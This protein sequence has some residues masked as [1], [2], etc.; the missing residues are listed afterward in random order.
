MAET[1]AAPKPDDWRKAFTRIS[2]VCYVTRK[3]RELHEDDIYDCACRQRVHDDGSVYACEDT[4]LNRIS[5]VECDPDTCNHG[6]FCRNQRFQ[7][8]Q[9]APLEVF[10]AD[11]K[12]WGIRAIQDVSAGQFVAEYLGELVDSKEFVRR[13]AQYT[14]EGR[15]HLFSMHISRDEIIDS[16]MKGS[17]SR[18]INHSC[19]PNCEAQKWTVQGETRIGFFTIKD[20]PKGTEFTFDYQFQTFGDTQQTCYCGSDNCRGTIGIPSRL[21]QVEVTSSDNSD[22]EVDF[23]E[24]KTKRLK[25]HRSRAGEDSMEEED[26]EMLV[27]RKVYLVDPSLCKLDSVVSRGQLETRI[28]RKQVFETSS[29]QSLVIVTAAGTQPLS[30]S[31]TTVSTVSSRTTIVGQ[32]ARTSSREDWRDVRRYEGQELIGT[33]VLE[34]VLAWDR[35]KPQIDLHA[36]NKGMG[37]EK[38][39]CGVIRI[40][41]EMDIAQLIGCTL[42]EFR[43]K[44]FKVL[45]NLDTKVWSLVEP[46]DPDVY[47]INTIQEVQD[48][49]QGRKLN[50]IKFDAQASVRP[51][52]LVP[53]PTPPVVS[54][55]ASS[56]ST[57]VERS[58]SDMEIDDAAEGN[59]SSAQRSKG[60]SVS[61]EKTTTAVSGEP[62]THNT[63]HPAAHA[64]GDAVGHA[65]AKILAEYY[66]KNKIQTKEDFK[67]LVVS[68]QKRIRQ[69]EAKRK[70]GD[71]ALRYQFT[72]GTRAGINHFVKEFFAKLS[73]GQLPVGYRHHS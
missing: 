62:D 51:P 48:M 60:E 1:S 29:L 49:L 9:N 55:P 6:D 58:L 42:R 72:D 14:K 5:F 67:A 45:C 17:E 27:R 3:K 59:P 23:A 20:V 57:R 34:V 11:K 31:A 47:Y 35:G 22:V 43:S 54:A 50:L 4:C 30:R 26:T 66:K 44:P 38:I 41:P 16:T 18:F 2:D 64:F 63:R 19:S 21:H 61:H 73:H 69:K 56:L 71:E 52:P 39:R 37:G 32:V 15:Q 40:T 12:G 8:K 70:Y 68:F 53:A 7:R 33:C 24:T 13:T 10:H 46:V 25:R 36:W 28:P 65:L